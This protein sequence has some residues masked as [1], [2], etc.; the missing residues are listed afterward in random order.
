MS[1]L[2][3]CVLSATGQRATEAEA[4]AA[5]FTA[6]AERS[7]IELGTFSDGYFPYDGKDLKAWMEGLKDR[8]R[9]DVVFTHCRDDAHQDH[10]EVCRLTWNTFREQSHP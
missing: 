2:H 4:S 7:N 1:N 8:V 3:W 6:G 9:P 10:R 5:V